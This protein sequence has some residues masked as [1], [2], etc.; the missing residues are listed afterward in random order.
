MS[1]NPPRIESA[2]D[3][4]SEFTPYRIMETSFGFA[5]AKTLLSAIELGVFTE[6]AK[7]ALD[8]ADLTER[9]ALHRRAARDFFDALVAL[10]MLERHDGK[11]S[12]APEPDYFL[13][14]A[15]PS[16]I[17][18]LLEMVNLRL[19]AFWGSLTEGLRT[20]RP[21]NEIKGGQN[22]FDA[23]YPN[24]FLLRIFLTA[25][26]GF[27][28]TTAKALAKKFPWQNY[29]TFVDMGTAQGAVPVEIALAHPHLTGGGFDLAPVAPFF[30]EYIAS[31]G[32]AGRLRFHPGDF[33]KDPLPS[34]DVLITARILHDWDLE[35]K[36][37]L[38]AKIYQALPAGGAYVVC[39]MLID[40]DRRERAMAL[41][42]SLNM[43]IETRGGF[44]FTG[45]DCCGW[46]RDAGFRETRVEHLVGADWLV[47]GIK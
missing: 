6:L 5:G 22:I 33:F 41:L 20:G 28:M 32:L 25:M 44:D 4:G 27:T 45:R 43:L 12:N 9:L 13:D 17:G 14:R 38:I 16:Y 40:D 2:N 23:I 26:T 30:D 35:E 19:Y 29:R 39:E 21:Q 24:P 36:R 8:A 3:A 10:G 34:A 18:G 42:M 31:F 11:Y 46:M 1:S 7:G 15:K 47:V 37:A